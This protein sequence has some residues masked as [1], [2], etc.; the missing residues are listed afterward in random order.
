MPRPNRGP[1][2][3]PNEFGVYEIRWTERGRSKRLST[4][5]R[6]LSE[7]AQVLV[8]WSDA[9]AEAAQPAKLTVRE[10]WAYYEEKHVQVKIAAAGGG[11]G[12]GALGV[13]KMLCARLGDHVVADL[14]RDKLD[15]YAQAHGGAPGT[16]RRHLALLQ[17]AFNYCVRH[18]QMSHDDLPAIDLPEAPAARYRWLTRPEAARLLDAS[19][20]LGGDGR[21]SRT[22]R[23]C[24]IA[25]RTAAR[26]AAIEQLRW[27]NG[28]VDFDARRIHFNPPGRRQ[29]KKRRASVPMTD[30]LHAMLVRAHRERTSDWV[31]DSPAKIDRP[32]ASLLKR[33][34]FPVLPAGHPEKV[35]PH[36]LR[37]TW[38]TWALRE[39]QSL[40]DVAKMLGDTVGTV[41]R[42]YGHHAADDLR[43]A[44]QATAEGG[45][46]DGRNAQVERRE[47]P[48]TTDK[49]A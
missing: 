3:E 12:N 17:A 5:T 15:G 4:G 22:Y 10:A 21:Y 40:W 1:R 16:I 30:D 38:A 19:Q 6:D 28:Q 7:A 31:L 2:L 11:D 49:A 26:E 25:L 9:K 41:E 32:F 34:G 44:A 35:T 37:H 39:G 47:S 23:F 18:K 20:Q 8:G 46:L 29:T 14:N 43:S 48:T 27:D 33:A 24:L 42:V 13:G 45:R 36:T